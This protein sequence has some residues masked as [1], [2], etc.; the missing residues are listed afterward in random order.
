VL[1][2]SVYEDPAEGLKYIMSPPIRAK[3]HQEPL[4]EALRDGT[5]QVTATDH[6]SFDYRGDKQIGRE[7]FTI[8]PNGAPGVEL[9]MPVLFS[10]GVSK[11]RID[12]KSFARVTSTNAAKL[13]G[14]YP[15]K[16]VLREGSDA[17]IV[18]FDPDRKVKVT[19]QILHDNCDYTP[20]E[21]MELT[22]WPVMTLIRGT[23]VVDNERLHVKPGFGQF[24]RRGKSMYEL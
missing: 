6:C 8:C 18:L 12:L 23:V 5:L 4:W 11:G 10:E 19:Q 2:D 9:R 15:E 13:F 22:G 17:D 21:G 14:M 3:G 7:D 24:I 16:G 1:D 20:Y